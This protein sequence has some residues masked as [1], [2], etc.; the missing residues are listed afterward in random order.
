MLKPAVPSFGGLT[1]GPAG[2]EEA[3]PGLGARPGVGGAGAAACLAIR[4]CACCAR[5]AATT[6]STSSQA[7][8][9]ALRA[10]SKELPV[11]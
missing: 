9:A 1:G 8:P 4:C 3:T 2:G 6:T 10:S 7:A 11:T 5:L